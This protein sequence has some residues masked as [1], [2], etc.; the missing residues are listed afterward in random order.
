MSTC[1]CITDISRHRK[2][3]IFLCLWALIGGIVALIFDDKNACRELR[4]MVMVTGIVLSVFSFLYLVNVVCWEKAFP[5]IL[6]INF[7][8]V[9]FM[10]VILIYIIYESGNDNAL[11]SDEC[12]DDDRTLP[13]F[14]IS[15]LSLF[16]FVFIVLVC[17]MAR[18]SEGFSSKSSRSVDGELKTL[19]L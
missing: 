6:L 4:Q 1:S 19:L 17:S 3:S 15:W 8:F 11:V 2:C 9:A 16:I 7:I 13:W 14:M 5:F 18:D 10:D 12:S